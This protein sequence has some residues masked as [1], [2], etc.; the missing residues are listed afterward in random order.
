MYTFS[1]EEEFP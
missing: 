1:Q